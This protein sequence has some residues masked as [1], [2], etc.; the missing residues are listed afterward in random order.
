MS[1][2][3]LA[4]LNDKQ[5]EAVQAGD[6]PLLVLAGPG[7]GKTRVL[8]HRV[9][10]LI[11]RRR[12]LPW[13][14]LAVT[15]TNKA[16]REMKERLARMIGAGGVAQLTIG[17]FHA[18][19]ARW[20]RIDGQHLGLDPR[21]VIYDSGDQQAAVKQALAELDLDEKRFRPGAM[22]AQISKA[23]SELIGPKEYSRQ[24]QDYRQEAVARIYS[25]YAAILTRANAL[26]FDDLLMKVAELFKD[27]PEI[28][29]KYQ[30]K[31]EHILVDEFQDTNP[32]QYAIV[33]QLAAL[34]RNILVVGDPDQSIYAF[35]SADIRNILNFEHDFPQA[36][37]ILLEQNYRSTGTILDTAQAVIAANRKRKKKK[38]WTENDAG[39]PATLFE[40]Y[41]E[42]E[43]A[44]FVVSEIQRLGARG[45]FTMGQCAVMYRTNAQ[46]RALEDAFV[47]K[48]LP[49]RLV[50]AT[51]FYERKEV[52]D[53]MAYLR[54]IH[55]PGD[56]IGLARIVG[57]PPRGIGAKTL[58]TLQQAAE[59]TGRPLYEVIRE[60]ATAGDAPPPNHRPRPGAASASVVLEGRATRALAE[61]AHLL[62]ELME[63][64]NRLNTAE[65]F[66]LLMERTAFSKFLRDGT[67]E[68]EERWANVMELRNL[69]VEFG[70]LPPPDW[71]SAF[72][73]Q[74]A[75]VSDIDN[76]DPNADA[77]T[78]LTLH[79]AKGLEFPVVFLVGL[80]EGIVPHSRS[81]EDPDAMEEER[82]LFYVG[83]TR[84]MERLYLI[85][86]FKRTQYGRS[87]A[88]EPSRF[89]RDIPPRL[90]KSLA[91]GPA[92]TRDE[93]RVT[94][95]EK[96]PDTR[97]PS[98]ATGARSARLP[99]P[100]RNFTRETSR[101]ESA[102]ER[103]A[104]RRANSATEFRV[105]D[106]VRHQTFGDG[107]V[108]SSEMRGDDEEVTVIFAGQKPKKLLQ[109][110][111]QL[112][113]V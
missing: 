103:T 59:K 90:L 11:E 94:S 108:I 38:L 24:A 45:L 89:L 41:N 57:V 65:L 14:I 10:W 21:F 61:F 48:S 111:A 88:G 17:T 95:D 1:D 86:A 67:D 23:K 19:C 113:K 7:S 34:R 62:A 47:K 66:D 87:E 15:F 3:L 52:K 22:L 110:F 98:S 30:D 82:R 56:S 37:T 33:K 55:N 85:R 77:A 84:A 78:L 97:H 83:I 6:G 58:T 35:R 73:E 104:S 29:R 72:L 105:G 69:A 8:T 12:V 101:R 42:D 36:R 20:L 26:D 112:Q 32:A 91:D 60:R 31:Y 96:Q 16:A 44:D 28:L 40:A 9:A 53:V 51:R 18:I 70:E 81:F 43:E 50:G 93:R 64:R 107:L 71:L 27:F 2:P 76:Y 100:D 75:L 39:L 79:T 54:V 5:Q 74:V 49:Y 13:K 106:K 63:A 102:R 68:G 80:E 92:Q 46:S 25:H 99:K 109:S 4:S